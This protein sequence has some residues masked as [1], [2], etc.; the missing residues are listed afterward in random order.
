MPRTADKVARPGR[1]VS[2][3]AEEVET[4]LHRAEDST[5]RLGHKE[6]A[7][8]VRIHMVVEGD[9]GSMVSNISNKGGKVTSISIERNSILARDKVKARA[10]VD[11][12]DNRVL[13]QI[14]TNDRPLLAL[15][16]DH[17]DI[18]DISD[19]QHC[20]TIPHRRIA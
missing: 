14:D 11:L 7:I 20:N 5:M 6:E 1:Q 19:L 17:E 15:C 16:F 13:V 12:T 9:L 2:L 3:A 18:Q 10:A 8:R 4:H